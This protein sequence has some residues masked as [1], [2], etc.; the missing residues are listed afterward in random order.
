MRS[1]VKLSLM[2]E[3][4]PGE[5][6]FILLLILTEIGMAMGHGSN[7]NSTYLLFSVN[8]T[9]DFNVHFANVVYAA[10]MGLGVY[11]SG[12]RMIK[13][14]GM[15]FVTYT[16]T[17]AFSAQFAAM[18][19]TFISS[20]VGYPIST[21]QA[22]FFALL[23]LKCWHNSPELV[24]MYPRLTKTIIVLWLVT[25]LLCVACPIILAVVY[26]LVKHVN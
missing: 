3:I 23:A 13:R 1:A 11:F 10:A 18:A 22:Y 5:E 25:P 21:S 24:V 17:S 16:N 19:T 9:V 12:A 15:N 20:V 4:I 26:R 14:V 6:H 2:L 7:S 8:V